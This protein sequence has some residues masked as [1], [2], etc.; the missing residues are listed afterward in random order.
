MPE[1]HHSVFYR[2]DTFPDAQL[3]A[4]KHCK[5]KLKKNKIQVWLPFMTSSLETEWAYSQRSRLVRKKEAS[6]EVK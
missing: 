5:N 1:P 6:R 2:L 4:S 3:T